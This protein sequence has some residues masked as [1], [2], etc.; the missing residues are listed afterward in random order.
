MLTDVYEGREQTKTKHRILRRYL[1]AFAPIIGSWAKDICYVD[2]FA[3]LGIAVSG[4]IGYVVY[5][6][7]GGVTVCKEDSGRSQ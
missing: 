1:S 4:P 5:P 3:G 2:C 7:L 6:S